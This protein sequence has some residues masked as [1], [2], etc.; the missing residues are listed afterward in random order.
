M[1]WGGSGSAGFA[2][3]HAK[4]KTMVSEKN[5]KREYGVTEED[6][7]SIPPELVSH[8][9]S[10]GNYYRSFRREDVLAVIAKKGGE[11]AVQNCKDKKELQDLQADLK[12]VD[13][14]L[15]EL[16]DRKEH[17]Q[18]RIT[19]VKKRLGEETE[20]EEPP[21]KRRRTRLA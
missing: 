17:L 16:S 19:E 20:I 21:K 14:E 1:P 3:A 8:R 7:D 4:A 18:S 9:S 6:L 11:E 13:K 5:A 12:K 2:A 15:Q 10:F